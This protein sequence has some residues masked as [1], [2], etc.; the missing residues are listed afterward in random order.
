M[1]VSKVMAGALVAGGVVWAAFGKGF[2]ILHE[3]VKY[4]VVQIIIFKSRLK[5]L[6]STLDD[7]APVVQEKRQ[8]SLAL[9]HPDMETKRFIEQVKK[10]CELVLECSKIKPWSWKYYFKAYSYSRKL[11]KLNNDIEKFRQIDLTVQNT[12]TPLETLTMV[13]QS[14]TTVLETMA[15]MDLVLE[16]GTKQNSESKKKEFGIRTLSCA[17][18]ESTSNRNVNE[19][20]NENETE[21]ENENDIGI[22]RATNVIPVY[23]FSPRGKL[24]RS[25]S[26]WQKGEFLGSGSFGTVYEGY[27]E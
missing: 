23:S 3:T 16:E 10:G 22:V 26:S 21:N 6:E 11:K 13:N 20:E 4:M 5:S 1:V 19:I 12:R 9:G 8:L 24:R 2:A 7:V 18:S 27:T 14:T 17:P 25:I 15:R